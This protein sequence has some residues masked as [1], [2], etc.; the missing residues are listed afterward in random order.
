MS[1]VKNIIEK[2]HGRIEV[3][4]EPGH[5]EFKVWLPFDISSLEVER[6]NG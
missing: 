5:T 2:H 1:I 4:S 6:K 3:K